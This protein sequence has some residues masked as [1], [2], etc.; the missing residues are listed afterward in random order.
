[1]IVFGFAYSPRF[2][3]QV[4]DARVDF[5]TD[6]AVRVRGPAVA[7]EVS[8]GDIDRL[9]DMADA[10]SMEADSVEQSEELTM[11]GGMATPPSIVSLPVTAEPGAADKLE[12]WTNIALR[13]THEYV[14][15]SGTINASVP[16]FL[17]RAQ[18]VGVRRHP[19]PSDQL[20][21]HMPGYITRLVDGT[22]TDIEVLRTCRKWGMHVLQEGPPGTGKTTA[23]RAT[24]GDE[25]VVRECYDGMLAQD[26]VGAH[27]PVPGQAG[28]FEWRDGPLVEAMLQGRPLLLD[29]VGWMPPGVQAMLLPALDDRQSIH[30][31]DRPEST[32]VEAKAGFCVLL[33]AN[34][35]VGYGVIDPLADRVAFRMQV[36]LDVKAAEQ[37]GVPAGFVK[38]AG[39]LLTLAETDAEKGVYRWV[40]PMRLLLR[41]R[42][43]TAVYDEHFAASAWMSEC[44]HEQRGKLRQ[45]LVDELD[46]GRDEPE[47]LAAR[48]R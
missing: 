29:D 44:P 19:L 33:N 22:R 24:F 27:L 35:G 13:F 32:V 34:P 17:S 25:L 9:G 46:F 7:P 20:E 42:D 36:P 45:L 14:G 1:M 8:A 21:S 30:V 12:V 6:A 37:L 41:A 10:V 40:P 28:V 11:S 43:L 4:N 15:M 5:V 23:A 18:N 31:M 16:D 3:D 38:V 2:G 26:L 48:V 47:V 39:V